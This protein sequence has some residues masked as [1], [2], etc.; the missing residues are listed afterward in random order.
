MIAAEM[1]HDRTPVKK[2]TMQS[3]MHLHERHDMPTHAKRFAVGQPTNGNKKESPARGV[4]GFWRPGGDDTGESPRELRSSEL[5]TLPPH[6][7]LRW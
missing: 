1:F 4:V 7:R 6:L 2:L 3:N 5:S